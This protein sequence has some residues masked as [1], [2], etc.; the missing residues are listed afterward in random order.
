MRSHALGGDLHGPRT[1][2]EDERAEGTTDEFAHLEATFVLSYGVAKR[3][4]CAAHFFHIRFLRDEHG[5]LTTARGCMDLRRF[6]PLPG[7]EDDQD[8]Y[9][10]I[11]D[12]LKQIL[13]W[14]KKGGVKNVLEL[15]VVFEQAKLLARNM[16]KDVTD[17][18]RRAVIL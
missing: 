4:E 14:R 17:F 1:V 11:K 15:N 10:N 18:S 3:L 6:A 5:I 9:V 13:K 16:E 2:P 7:H 12:S 8:N